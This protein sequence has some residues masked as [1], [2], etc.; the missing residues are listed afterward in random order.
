[1]EVCSLL[2]SESGKMRLGGA[3]EERGEEERGHGERPHL[4]SPAIKFK[5]GFF[6]L[7]LLRFSGLCGQIRKKN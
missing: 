3:K 4:Q 2:H 7:P 1:M 5:S 6:P